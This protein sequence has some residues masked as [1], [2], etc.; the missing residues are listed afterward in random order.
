MA[1]VL[2]CLGETVWGLR[3][4]SGEICPELVLTILVKL[5]HSIGGTRLNFFRNRHLWKIKGAFWQIL[6]SVW[7]SVFAL[8]SF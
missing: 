8:S 2:Q 7:F 4:R 1:A 3:E 5:Y 6:K